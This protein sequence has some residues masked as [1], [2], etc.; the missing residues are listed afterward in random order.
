MQKT[1]F[2]KFEKTKGGTLG[3]IEKNQR[4]DPWKNRKIFRFFIIKISGKKIPHDQKTRVLDAASR[5]E[6]VLGC[7]TAELQK[8]DIADIKNFYL[9]FGSLKFLLLNG[10]DFIV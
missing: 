2:E 8:R 4:G 5:A 1:K 6:W 3:K 10:I 9:I 7:S